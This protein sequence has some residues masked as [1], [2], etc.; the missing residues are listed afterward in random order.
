MAAY[1]VLCIDGGGIRGVVPALWLRE[2]ERS[3]SQ[4]GGKTIANYVNLVCGTSTGAIVAAAIAK[5]ISMTELVATFRKNG[6]DIFARNIWPHFSIYGKMM[7]RPKY[8]SRN[9]YEILTKLLGN[10]KLSQSSVN[11][12]MTAYDIHLRRI[13]LMRSYDKYTCDIT[14]RDAC[15]ASASAPTYFQPFALKEGFEETSET[16]SH[17]VDGGL[18]ANNPSALGI[19]EAIAINEEDSIFDLKSD[20][21]LL[22]LGTGNIV[23]SLCK[24]ENIVPPKSSPSWLNIM[25]GPPLIDAMFDATSVFSEHVC[26]QILSSENYLRLQ[27]QLDDSITNGG[28]DNVHPKNIENLIAMSKVYM[29]HDG[30]KILKD[31]IAILNRKSTVSAKIKAMEMPRP[32]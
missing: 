6:A 7:F 4:E 19:A 32:E 16:T 25:R 21:H 27:I 29:F 14:L 15:M 2:I 1:K 5:N 30:G 9:L 18:F 10:T 13:V 3:L 28:L 8:N 12:C 22:S 20:L 23:K 11:I 26:E 24:T 17:L 31:A